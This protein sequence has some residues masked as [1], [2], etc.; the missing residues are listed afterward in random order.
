VPNTSSRIEIRAIFF[1]TNVMSDLIPFV[2]RMTLVHALA[3]VNRINSDLFPQWRFVN[4]ILL[5]SSQII[6]IMLKKDNAFWLILH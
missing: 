2:N 5:L 1:E 3:T 6:F 4:Q